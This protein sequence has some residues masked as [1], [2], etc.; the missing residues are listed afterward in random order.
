MNSPLSGENTLD[1][2]I[3]DCIRYKINLV[4]GSDYYG[5]PTVKI[6]RFSFGIDSHSTGNSISVNIQNEEGESYNIIN[7]TYWFSSRYCFNEFKQESG[8]WD[9]ALNQA[10]QK[11]KNKI[12]VAKEEERIREEQSKQEKVKKELTVKQKFEALFQ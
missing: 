10:I 11:L 5:N 3:L 9:E 1:K 4:E 7:G 12:A 6:D 2:I 8:K